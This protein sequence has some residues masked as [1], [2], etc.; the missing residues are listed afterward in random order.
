[1]KYS[2]K[3]LLS[4]L[5]AA[6]MVFS[7][8]PAGA[9]A[10]EENANGVP[11]TR[12]MSVTIEPRVN[13][14]Y[15]GIVDPDTLCLKKHDR[16]PPAV[17]PDA[18]EYGTLSEAVADLR[19]AMVKRQE[20]V[21]VHLRSASDDYYS[22]FDQVF[23]E[24][25]EHTG[26]PV[27]GDY[28]VWQFLGW[29]G[30]LSMSWDGSRYCYD[31]NFY[32]SYYTTPAQ[33]AVMDAEVE[34][35]LDRLDLYDSPDYYKVKGI[36]DWICANITY[37]HENLADNSYT[38][39]HTAYAALID[40]TAVCQGYAALLYRLALTL[41]VDCRLI[42]GG[43][44]GWNIVKLGEWYYYVDSTWDSEVPPAYFSY[45]LQ[46]EE[47]FS[48]HLRED[49]SYYYGEGC[50]YTSQE[51]Y[52]AYPMSP[53]DFSLSSHAHYWRTTQTEPN[54]TEPGYN[55]STCTICGEESREA[56]GE[57]LGHD[58]V[59]ADCDTPKTCTRCE[60]TEGE[61]LGHDWQ[62][63]DCEHAGTCTRCGETAEEPLGHD[64]ITA[65][66]DTP[67]T[68][69][70]CGATD[71]EA[72][73]HDWTEADCENP[74][75]CT[76][77]EATEG[78]A[79]GHDWVDADCDTPKTCTRC[80]V[81]EG[82]ALGHDWVDA[83]CEHPGTCSR[84]G[85]TTDEPLGHDW[86]YTDCEIPATCSRC[87]AT[88]EEALGHDWN[89]ADCDT[90]QT[91]VRCGATEGEA[92]GHDWIAADCENPAT[93]AR[94][95]VTEGEALGHNWVD[96]DCENPKTCTRCEVTEG[97]ALGHNW[98]DADCENPKTC[99]RCEATEGEA[100][101]HDWVDADCENPK[102][103]TRCEVTEG[104]ALGHDWVDADCENPRT[105]ARCG[106]TEGEALGHDYE[107]GV[108]TRCGGEESILPASGTCGE[109][110]TWVLD[111]DGRLTISGT[112]D[113]NNYSS[114]NG[115]PWD[116]YSDLVQTI[117]VEGTVNSV[118][119]Y[120]F[121][122]MNN[123]TTVIIE[124]GVASI[125]SHSMKYC[126]N[127]TYVS[128]PATVTEMGVSVFEQSRKLTTAG[129]SGS[130]CA[131]EFGWTETIP[132][133]TFMDH[134]HLETVTLPDTVTEIGDGAF[135]K[136]SGLTWVDLPE[137]LETIGSRAFE[138]TGLT[139]VTI[140]DSVTEIGSE[141][142]ELCPLTNVTFGTS[143]E[144][145]GYAAFRYCDELTDLAMPAALREI[146][147]SAFEGGNALT[148][149]SLN[150]G[151][152]TIGASA[153]SDCTALEQ[154]EIPA[155]VTEI[156]N[157]AFKN[158]TAMDS[159]TFRGDAPAIA[160]RAFAG[161]SATANYPGSNASWTDEVRKNYGGSLTWVAYGCADGV[162]RLAGANRYETAFAVADQLKEN[163][164]IEQ[165]ETVVVAYGQNFPDALTGS[166]LAAVKNAPILLTEASA[167]GEVLAYIRGNL[168]P[169]G[170]VYILGGSSAVGQVF[171]LGAKLL[172]YEVKRLKGAGRY[173]TN[174]AILEEAGVN[175]TDE[176]L[177]ATGK[178]YADSLSASASGLPMLLVG[179]EL[180]MEQRLFLMRTS[181][182]F[183]ILGGIGA[184]SEAVEEEL[185]TLG[186]VERVKGASRY[187][188]SVEIAKR[189]FE[190]PQ[191]A[192]L[193]YANGFP[194]GLCG[195]P[196]ALS[197]GAPLIL[198]SNDSYQIADEYVE[199]IPTGAVTG[200][201]GRISD[202]TL[203]EIF[204]LSADVPISR[205]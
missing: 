202:E 43:N 182:K 122:G 199:G 79:L 177:I 56:D 99:T 94:C 50:D 205:P 49:F 187:G 52:D 154:I 32:I 186:T 95:E 29:S 1:M 71:G 40:R 164:G 155:S 126:D 190:N 30:D 88:A 118:G 58:W 173:E 87:G 150:A 116:A 41:G 13:P 69:T 12:R 67:K 81:T 109:G 102:T 89:A 38:L 77:C 167:D 24:A 10:H 148:E 59:D 189:F 200:G 108:C 151:L 60:A 6:A 2:V 137:N 76:R 82:E 174:L 145:I 26:N 106:E 85:E 39:K 138:Q 120:A 96:A 51:F 9:H 152:V 136:C 141:A 149:V 203:R 134:I 204:D 42:A 181:R 23:F 117:L 183:V 125:G 15:E 45:F 16:V 180:T 44:H 201:I 5:V 80:E 91:C 176:V 62:D 179:D 46:N 17:A 168:V 65:D 36:Y 72:L 53:V 33:E 78:E 153:F 123:L 34:K 142:F 4:L 66:C 128:I 132:G 198:T 63:A 3:R 140:P 93:C 166:Y 113:M 104:E 119:S 27:E 175:T 147:A 130:G 165:F 83:D 188:T 111:L 129:P 185:R 74:K 84:C 68:C 127:L 178:N 48:D 195:G 139:S 114:A 20:Y 191:A 18:V 172:G 115:T 19:E 61:A 157:Y 98:V 35:L 146:G 21:T 112:G 158:C 75:T 162:I 25:L 37:D 73:G 163:L 169:G 55:V 159:I 110:V 144:T 103:C 47:G 31:F 8:L 156:G 171:E 107:D 124:S 57:A 160:E 192:V 14:L 193:A 90:P 121:Y 92:L 70:R 86:S 97:E 22:L 64:W 131:I 197:M 194:D 54:C 135:L 105:C 184:V 161:V 170:R 133:D 196:L 28:L 100:L 101:G 11:G 7:M 143:V